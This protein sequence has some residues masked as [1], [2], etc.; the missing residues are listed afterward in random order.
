MSTVVVFALMSVAMLTVIFSLGGEAVEIFDDISTSWIE[1]HEETVQQLDAKIIRT[2]ETPTTRG[3][4]VRLIM[5]NEGKVALSDFADW[6]VIVEI[7]EQAELKV[8][9][10]T[11][12]TSTT[13][14]TDEWGIQAI[15]TD[16]AS[17]TSE[18]AEPGVLNPDEEMIVMLNATS[19]LIVGTYGRATF[20]TPGGASAS[21]IFEVIQDTTYYLHN[22]PT[23]PTGDTTSLSV[24]PTD[25]T[26]STSTTLYN[27]DTNRNA[28]SGLLIIRGGVGPGESDSTKKQVWRSGA[29][30]DSLLIAG[31]ATVDLWSAIKDFGLATSGEVSIY[32][33]DYNG[34]THTEI[35]NGTLTD[36]DWQAGSSTWVEKSITLTGLNYTI[37]AGNELEIEVTVGA[38]AGDDMW[39]AYDTTAYLSAFNLP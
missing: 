21:V 17:L 3:P 34:S 24:L 5:R 39:L 7:D 31:N 33:R 1:R 20:A 37:A 25:T 19:S 16:A 29:L 36:S 18:H 32:L 38:S 13:I 35:G 15:Y 14:A 27:Y 30:T 26:A 11:Y 6:N 28:S 4:F 2:T 9:S 22:D 12:T 10:L 23:P 8:A